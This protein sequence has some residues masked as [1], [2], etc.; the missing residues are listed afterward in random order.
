[1]Q[2]KGN[3]M[4]KRILHIKNSVKKS[5]KQGVK[6]SRRRY[7]QFRAYVIERYRTFMQW[8]GSLEM[9][10]QNRI[11]LLIISLVLICDYFMI[12]G[13]AGKN[14]AS[15]FPSLPVLDFR[16]SVTVYL[17]SAEGSLLKEKRLIDTPSDNEEFIRRL[18]RFVIEGS[19]YENT[20]VMTPIQGDVR[21]VWIY[22]DECYIDIR[23]ET[24]ESD[25]PIVAGSEKIFREALTKT[26]TDNV[27][28]IKKVLVLENGIPNK[29]L[30]ESPVM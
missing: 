10:K 28:N 30:W 21:K 23:L 22:N 20:R 18:A 9:R 14:P 2:I 17:P 25:A 29:N 6:E 16:D 15:I 4:K 3:I 19:A 7:K 11:T 1:M 13:L 12:C 26:V 24:L 5:V 8:H 27:K